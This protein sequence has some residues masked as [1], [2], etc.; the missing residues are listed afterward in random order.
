M[1]KLMDSYMEIINNQTEQIVTLSKAEK[2][3]MQDLIN[4]GN[5]NNALKQVISKQGIKIKNQ[6]LLIKT[7]ELIIESNGLTL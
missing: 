1:D 3:H 4:I 5:E 7:M 2:V 6:D